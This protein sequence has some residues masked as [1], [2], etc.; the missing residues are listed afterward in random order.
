ME[1]SKPM[2]AIMKMSLRTMAVI[3]A[4]TCLGAWGQAQEIFSDTFPG[5]GRNDALWRDSVFL[6]STAQLAVTNGKVLFSRNPFTMDSFQ[7]V[8]WDAKFS[9]LYDN[10]DFLQIEATVRIPHKIKTGDGVYSLGIGLVSGGAQF[11]ELSVED[12]AA[13]RAFNLFFENTDTG[14]NDTFI[15]DAPQNVTVFDLFITYTA[16]TDTLAFYWSIPGVAKLFRIGQ[17]VDFAGAVGGVAPRRIRPYI[18]GVMYNDA[19]VPPAWR[20]TLDDFLAFREDA[21]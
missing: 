15:I 11:V 13:G 18:I 3:L 16:A 19:L 20:V 12:S 6:D 9:R 4:A 5:P 2:G 14:T 8:Q 7:Q 17:F 21:P 1:P 10:N